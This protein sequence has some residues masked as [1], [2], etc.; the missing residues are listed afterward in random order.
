MID[1]LHI[2]PYWLSAMVLLLA[3][4]LDALIGDPRW[5]IH[6]VQLIGLQ[7]VTIERLLRR[8]IVASPL[9]ERLAGVTLA[10]TV[11]IGVFCV[12]YAIQ[13]LLLWLYLDSI[14]VMV[15]GLVIVILTFITATTIA[16]RG[17]I[18]AC[19]AV[20]DAVKRGDI[21]EARAGVSM[22]V[23]RDTAHLTTDEILRAV[24]ETLSENLSDGVVAPMFYYL[25][26]GF[27]LAMTYK[28]VNTLDSMVGYKSERYRYFGWA[29]ARIDDIAN[30]IP[31]RLTALFIALAAALP[32]IKA[33]TFI[34]SIH[35]VLRDGRKHLSPNSGYPEAAMAGAVSVRLGGPSYYEGILVEKPYIGSEKAD[36]L[37]ASERSIVVA[38]Y[39]ITVATLCLSGTLYLR[40]VL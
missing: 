29:S 30:Y 12:A 20:I 26:G 24:I 15:H 17:L 23:G 6:P 5:M 2:Q 36:Y 31:A 16:A 25:I 13:R 4:L 10:V 19:T 32:S 22:I 1:S 11:I 34:D 38:R 7:I 28:A 21:T 35:T 9:A 18:D 14:S 37:R 8:G 27:P 33:S 3:V 40:G 39:T